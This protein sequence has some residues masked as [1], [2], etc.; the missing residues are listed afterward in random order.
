MTGLS[1]GVDLGQRARDLSSGPVAGVSPVVRR[2]VSV[3]IAA[4]NEQHEI[5][6]AVQSAWQ[7]GA[8]EVIVADGGSEDE[9][10]VRAVAAAAA[11]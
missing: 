7:A 4:L 1:A 3:V 9:T 11:R 2:A 5:T 6:G 8:D 10:V